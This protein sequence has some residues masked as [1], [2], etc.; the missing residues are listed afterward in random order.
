MSAYDHLP[1]LTPSRET[2]WYNSIPRGEP[3]ADEALEEG[4]RLLDLLRTALPPDKVDAVDE[5]KQLLKEAASLYAQARDA[6]SS[7]G[8]DQQVL[9][10]LLP[11]GK[12]R[13]FQQLCQLIAAE[14]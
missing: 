9:E 3:E 14:S 2:Q 11:P 4:L 6:T 10:S 12:R 1:P 5:A 7:L 13:I 8:Q